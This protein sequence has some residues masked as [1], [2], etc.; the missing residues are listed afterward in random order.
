MHYIYEAILV[1]IITILIGFPVS[2]AFMYFNNPEFKFE[3]KL[4]LAT[5]LFVIGFLIHIV[6]EFTGINKS[7][8]EYGYACKSTGESVSL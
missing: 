6:C 1:G 4:Q 7:Y 2:V 3:F 8:C 5:S